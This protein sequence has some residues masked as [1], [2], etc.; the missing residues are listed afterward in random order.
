MGLEPTIFGTTIRRV[1]QL[2]YTHHILLSPSTGSLRQGCGT[3]PFIK[4]DRFERVNEPG[5]IRTLDLRLRRPLLYPAE[6]QTHFSLNEN[7]SFS[8]EKRVMGIEPT[9]PAWKAG[10]LPLNYTRRMIGVTGFEPA[11]SWSQTRRSSQ[12]EP[13]PDISFISLSLRLCVSFVSPAATRYIIWHVSQKVNRFFKVFLL[14]CDCFFTCFPQEECANC[15]FC[16]SFLI[17]RII[18]DIFAQNLIFRPHRLP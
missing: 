1:N 7:L 8:N 14:F 12:A 15:F 10:V 4:Y 9:Y 16:F 3:D 11:T 6:L 5:G 17:I 13:H 2:H 18:I